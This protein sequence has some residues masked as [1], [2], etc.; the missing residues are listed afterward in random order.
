M[1]LRKRRRLYHTRSFRTSPK[2]MS[3]PSK[4]ISIEDAETSSRVVWTA[5]EERTLVSALLK[6]PKESKLTTVNWTQVASSIGKPSKGAPKTAD[7]CKNKWSRVSD[8]I[9]FHSTFVN[10]SAIQ[11]R[12]AYKTVESIKKQS[13]FSTWT[14]DHGLR[15]QEDEDKSVWNDYVKVSV[16]PFF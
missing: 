14:P 7:S 2:V 11:L 1:N 6:H 9:L 5:D 8:S 15:F 13:G 3:G 16:S 4:E 10:Y 12:E